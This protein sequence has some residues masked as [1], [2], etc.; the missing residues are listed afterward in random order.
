MVNRLHAPFNVAPADEVVL[1][2]GAGGSIGS[3]LAKRLFAS[4]TNRDLSSQHVPTQQCCA[5]AWQGVDRTVI[6]LD[7]SE[8][9]LYEIHSE[10]SS[11]TTNASPQF[12]PILGDINDASLLDELFE[13]YRPKKI[14]HAAAFKH[15][16]LMEE[17]PIAVIRN[18]ILGTWNLANIAAKHRT[19]QLTMISTDKAANPR[20]IMGAAKRVAE[21]VLTRLD[22]PATRMRSLRLGNVLGS[23]GSV[24]PLFQRQIQ[25]GGPVTVTHP[26]ARRYFLSLEEAT[27]LILAAAALEDN[28]TLFVPELD[29]PIKILDLAKKMIREAAAPGATQIEIVFTGLCPGE[30]L[31][32][33]LLSPSETA[34]PTTKAKLRRIVGPM[35]AANS[36]DAAIT[37]ISEKVQ[38]RE[39]PTLIETI[40]KLVPDYQ[41]SEVLSKQTSAQLS[42]TA[43]A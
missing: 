33:D 30:K 10:F 39:L 26:E 2:T 9:N 42:A 20:S 17:N 13:T 18:N 5:P 12:I 32:E 24:V 1:I 19:R 21:L 3:A 8:Q 35:P 7:H 4:V 16:P 41:A 29:A 11:S 15:V 37:V 43:K 6:L 22:S 14:F 38:S 40:S 23:T 31:H 36:L 27:N 34:E 25:N 28:A